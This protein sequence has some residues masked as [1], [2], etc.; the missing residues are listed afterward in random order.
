MIRS[1][2][3]AAAAGAL[4]FAGFAAAPAALAAEPGATDGR[5]C[6]PR[7][8]IVALLTERYREVPSGTGVSETGDAAFE[9]FRSASGSW[10]ITMT[11]ANGVT[12]V[13]AAGRDWQDRNLVALLPAT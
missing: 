4:A 5:T 10:T 1:I 6:A 2:T 9:M 13:M 3:H 8:E 11:T 7:A 12:C